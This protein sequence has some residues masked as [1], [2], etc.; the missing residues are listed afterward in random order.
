[1]DKTIT[2]EFPAKKLEAL[3]HFLK[4]PAPRSRLPESR[5]YA[6]PP[7]APSHAPTS[8]EG[9]SF[10]AWEGEINL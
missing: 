7:P 6:S 10:P 8:P 4:K 2:L 9:D 5:L 1:M 3:A